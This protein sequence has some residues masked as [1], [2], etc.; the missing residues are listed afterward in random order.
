M[1]KLE[2]ENEKTKKEDTM[3]L[4]KDLDGEALSFRKK[5]TS[6]FS[7]LFALALLCGGILLL[8]YLKQKR[9]EEKRKKDFIR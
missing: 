8:P 1:Q 2:E 4:P 5:T 3:I 7:Y 6:V 9:W